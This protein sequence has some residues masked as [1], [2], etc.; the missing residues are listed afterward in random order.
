VYHRDDYPTGGGLQVVGI[1][2]PGVPG[3]P[4]TVV[5]GTEVAV[6][7]PFFSSEM[8]MLHGI[9]LW[10]LLVIVTGGLYIGLT[11]DGTASGIC[12][13]GKYREYSGCARAQILQMNII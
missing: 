1:L 7:V 6:P 2:Y 11:T 8:V 10:Q 5:G 12:T 9:P 3:A 13:D 4:G